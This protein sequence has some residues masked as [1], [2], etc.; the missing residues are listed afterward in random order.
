MG[1][2]KKKKKKCKQYGIKSVT[3]DM[4]QGY[5]EIGRCLTHDKVL[6]GDA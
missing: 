4:K 3:F 2:Q 1:E 6:W 5:L